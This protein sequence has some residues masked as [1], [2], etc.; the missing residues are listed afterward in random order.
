MVSP[1]LHLWCCGQFSSELQHFKSAK[2]PEITV[3]RKQIDGW[4]TSLYHKITWLIQGFK[5]LGLHIYFIFW[6]CPYPIPIY[7]QQMF[8][9]ISRTKYWFSFYLFIL[10]EF[11]WANPV[12]LTY[13]MFSHYSQNHIFFKVEDFYLELETI[14]FSC[15][16][17]GKWHSTHY[18]VIIW[19]YFENLPGSGAWHAHSITEEEE[20]EEEAEQQGDIS[21]GSTVN[22][23]NQGDF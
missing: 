2:M 12:F 8:T 22:T 14:C 5:F 10:T 9:N 16:D 18:D 15:K 17:S 6:L 4:W 19:F 23:R 13:N 20:E 11:S 3:K 7:M 21:S 1:R